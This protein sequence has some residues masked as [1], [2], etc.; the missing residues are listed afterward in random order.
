MR[1][2]GKKMKI[3]KMVKEKHVPHCFLILQKHDKAKSIP[4]HLSSHAKIIILHLFG[5][6]YCILSLPFLWF[7]IF[8]PL[9]FFNP[10]LFDI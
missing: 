10:I 8:H 6:A 3:I 4:L 5:L 2:G 9:T 1:S 7:Y